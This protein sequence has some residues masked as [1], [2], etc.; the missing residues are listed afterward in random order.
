MSKFLSGVALPTSDGGGGGGSATGLDGNDL[1]LGA[2]PASVGQGEVIKWNANVAEWRL[3]RADDGPHV[4]RA[5]A[6]QRVE[7]DFTAQSTAFLKGRYFLLRDADGSVGVWFSVDADPASAP[8]TGADRDIEIL[9]LAGTHTTAALIAGITATTLDADPAFSSSVTATVAGY[10][11]TATVQVNNA[12]PGYVGYP[13]SGTI[14]APAIAVAILGRTIG[15]YPTVASAATIAGNETDITKFTH[16]RMVLEGDVVDSGGVTLDW[17]VSIRGRGQSQSVWDLDSSVLTVSAD[18]GLPL[19][20]VEFHDMVLLW[21][22]GLTGLVFSGVFGDRVLFKNC[23]MTSLAGTLVMEMTGTTEVTFEDCFID[24]DIDFSG[25]GG[26]LYL[27]NTTV[28]GAVQPPAQGLWVEDGSVVGNKDFGGGGIIA[29][30]VNVVVEDSTVHVLQ[31][32]TGAVLTNVLIDYSAVI[33]GGARA[34]NLWKNVRVDVNTGAPLQLSG[35]A[36]EIDCE[37]CTFIQEAGGANCVEV[38]GNDPT[39]GRSHWFKQCRFINSTVGG[40][41]LIRTDGGLDTLVL[42][43]C[44][45]ELEATGVPVSG[46]LVVSY[47]EQ[48]TQAHD[49][50]DTAI[51]Q[52]VLAMEFYS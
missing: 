35:A 46:N 16:S 52:A 28:Y 30:G 26:R 14:I 45:F 43:A 37:D 40:V 31:S 17:P 36:T 49:L 11:P 3:E 39:G 27:R 38:E 6:A 10:S 34:D 41:G 29:V 1:A 15:T 13:E 7:V 19:A 50:D 2:M 8:V 5:E 32:D 23:M 22:T 4:I 25:G 42:T 20:S 47:L 48:R 33:S 18:T 51:A 9:L 21:R 24:G 44:E 12:S